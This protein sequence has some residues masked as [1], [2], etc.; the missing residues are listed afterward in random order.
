MIIGIGRLITNGNKD[1]QPLINSG[2]AIFHNGIIIN[3]KKLF[4]LEKIKKFSDIDS[5]IIL[6]MANKYIQEYKIKIL[7]I[8]Y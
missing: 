5:E 2:S 8:S 4:D 6:S 7:L 1:N 3:E